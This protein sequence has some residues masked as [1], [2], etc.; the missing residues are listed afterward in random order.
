MKIETK[1]LIIKELTMDMAFDIHKNSLDEDNRRFVPDEVFETVESAEETISFLMEQ[2]ENKSGP[3]VYA[4][5]KKEDN[6]N[7][8]Y[9]QVIPLENGEFEIGYHIAKEYTK[10]GYAT[11]AVKAFLPAGCELVNI[12]SI[13]GICLKENV[14]S[15]RVLEKCGFV[16]TFDGLGE[17]QGKENYISKYEWNKK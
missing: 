16:E 1:R 4:I 8:G 9:I 3:L 5:I 17:Y 10:N 7:I 12:S 15:C 6:R 11:E 14:A 13:L 2:Y